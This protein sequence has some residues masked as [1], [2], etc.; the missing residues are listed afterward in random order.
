[1]S[2]ISDMNESLDAHGKPDDVLLRAK[3]VREQAEMLTARGDAAYFGF[4]PVCALFWYNRSDSISGANSAGKKFQAAVAAG[5][6]AEAKEYASTSPE[7]AVVM[8]MGGEPPHLVARELNP[9]IT[10]AWKIG[11]DIPSLIS[12]VMT[13]LSPEDRVLVCDIL[14]NRSTRDDEKSRVCSGIGACYMS[15]GMP[16]EARQMFRLALRANPSN[17]VRA[18]IH[19]EIGWLEYETGNYAA[20]S[21]A[22]LSALKMNERFPAAWAGLAR[23][24]ISESK[25]QEALA[26]LENAVR[27]HPVNTAYQEMREAVQAILADPADETADRF[28]ALGENAGLAAAAAL[29]AE[30]SP[31]GFTKDVWDV[32]SVEDVL[33]YR[34]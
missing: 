27:Q 8:V 18:R 20:S 34:K 5:L 9:A 16:D 21:D 17:T 12:P 4:D 14:T 3:D 33:R 28:F 26:A 19:S 15:L 24:C 23:S 25:Y 13:M 6:Y 31:S 22:Y 32:T 7:K 29:Y 30:K 2:R 1:M 11:G 10:N